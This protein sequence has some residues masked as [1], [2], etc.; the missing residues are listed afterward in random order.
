MG[1][2]SVE[3]GDVLDRLRVRD[4]RSPSNWAVTDQG[5]DQGQPVGDR[6]YPLFGESRS[7]LGERGRFPESRLN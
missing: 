2:F 1:P 5:T 6:V 4:K 3:L 7:I